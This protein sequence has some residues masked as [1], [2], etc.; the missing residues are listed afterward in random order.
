MVELM[1]LSGNGRAQSVELRRG[2][3][4]IVLQFDVHCMPTMV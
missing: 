1:P 2:A 4:Y 3:R